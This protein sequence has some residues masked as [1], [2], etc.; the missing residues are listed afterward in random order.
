MDPESN[1]GYDSVVKLAWNYLLNTVPNDPST[2]KPAYYSRSYINP[3]TQQVVDWPHNPAGLYAMLVESALKY[4]A[5]SGN[6]SVMQLAETVAL[7]HLDHGMTLSTDS[8]ASVPYSDGDAG[9]LTY[10]GA[11]QDGDGNLEPDKIGELGYAWLQLYKYDG[12]TRFRDAA[13]QAANV[14][15]SK[16]RVGSVS[17]SP[18]PFRVKAS[19]NAVIEEYCADVVGPISLFD[20]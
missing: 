11:P 20:D 7:W 15:S 9:S 13:I 14:L 8:W 4:Y 1:L 3:N 16:I 10:G 6:T 19:N 12:N 17:Q 18:W 5:Y 2:G